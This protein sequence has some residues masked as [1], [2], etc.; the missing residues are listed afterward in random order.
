MTAP[1][2]RAAARDQAIEW[3]ETIFAVRRRLHH[4]FNGKFRF[5][6]GRS[7]PAYA[8]C[9]RNV[10]ESYFRFLGHLVET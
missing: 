1:V 4:D 9:L 8:E 2:T 5:N 7:K 6:D 10:T 3:D